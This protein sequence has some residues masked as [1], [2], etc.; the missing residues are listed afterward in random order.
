MLL[1][2]GMFA[3]ALGQFEAVLQKEP[4]RFNAFAGAAASARRLGDGTKAR[5]YSEKLLRLSSGGDPTRPALAA[6]RQLLAP[7]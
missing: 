5:N 2:R 7:R 4:N 6:A 1:E 3:E